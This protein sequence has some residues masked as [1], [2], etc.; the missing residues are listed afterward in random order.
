MIKKE[1]ILAVDKNEDILALYRQHAKEQGYKTIFAHSAEEALTMLEQVTVDLVISEVLLPELDGYELCRQLKANPQ[2]SKIPFVF[3]SEMTEL[4]ELIVGY[5]LGADEYITKPVV[6]DQFI[7]KIKHIL[8]VNK[9]N[10][11]VQQQLD[12]YYKTAM[13]AMTYSSEIGIILEFYKVCISARSFRELANYIF[14]SVKQLDLKCSFQI[15]D[16]N[17]KPTG[18]SEQGEL[19]PLEMEIMSLARG[20][21]RFYDFGVRTIVSYEKFSLL[22]K[23]MPI[24]DADKYGRLKDILGT[25]CDAIGSRVDYILANDSLMQKQ[26]VVEMVSTTMMDIDSSFSVLQKENVAA[27]E[28]MM[29]NMEEALLVLGLAEHQEDSI[30]KIS[31]ACLTR[32]NNAF[33]KGVEINTKLDELHKQL[34]TIID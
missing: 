19:P 7:L 10:E 25:L 1:T 18:F 26:E 23:N 33:Y 32:I 14:M 17:N 12:N 6:Y 8:R 29:E 3:V 31:R 30:L 21:S 22:I 28:D 24:D 15:Y 9:K 5:S 11:E 34:V 13:Q 2:T 27:L 16:N 20:Q 4:E